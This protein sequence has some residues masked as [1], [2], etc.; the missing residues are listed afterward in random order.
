[1]YKS[2]N[3]NCACAKGRRKTS[4]FRYRHNSPILWSNEDVGRRETVDVRKG[5]KISELKKQ[6]RNVGHN[7]RF[8][9]N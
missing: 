4:I 3:F 7:L 8:A 9:V 5:I 2:I 6:V 1:M